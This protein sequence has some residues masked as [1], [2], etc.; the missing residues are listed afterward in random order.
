[1]KVLLGAYL[2]LLLL[3][4]LFGRLKINGEIVD[5]IILRFLVSALILWIPVAFIGLPIYGIIYL[6][7]K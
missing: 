7:T 1:M 4:T 6:L 5:D 3:F 2:I